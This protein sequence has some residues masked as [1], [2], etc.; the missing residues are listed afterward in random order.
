[1]F[2]VNHSTLIL[3]SGLIWLGVGCMLLSL[4]INFI[5]ESIL[6]ENLQQLT[7]PILDRLS[8]YVGGLDT[9]ALILI[10]LS[11]CMGYLKGRYIL[12]KTAKREVSRIVALPS[13]IRFNQLYTKKYYILLGVMIFLGL[14]MKLAALDVRGAVDVTV[15]SA[16]ISGA[17]LY[18]RHGRVSW[19]QSLKPS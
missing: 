13:P 14:L 5:V 7:R 12:R 2:K 11:L 10:G 18:F 15:G 3:I 8:P 6:K 16:L 4:G 9:A 1:M 17:I 19:R